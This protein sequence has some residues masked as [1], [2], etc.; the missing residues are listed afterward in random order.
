METF[1][2]S[3]PQIVSVAVKMVLEAHIM[4]KVQEDLLAGY[5]RLSITKNLGEMKLSKEMY[6]KFRWNLWMDSSYP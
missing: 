4:M 1:H 6:A 2:S 5:L 3:F